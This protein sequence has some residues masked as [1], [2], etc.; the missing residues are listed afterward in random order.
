MTTWKVIQ[1]CIAHDEPSIS[2]SNM[3][4]SDGEWESDTD[5]DMMNDVGDQDRQVSDSEV[6]TP[7]KPW[8]ECTCHLGRY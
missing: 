7:R 2:D 6:S 8:R 3:L 4:E 1:H 5:E